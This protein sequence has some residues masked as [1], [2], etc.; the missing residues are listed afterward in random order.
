MSERFKTAIAIAIS[1]VALGIIIV[2]VSFTSAQEPTADD[3]VAALSAS[4]K[5]PFCSGESL[6][7]SQSGVARDYREL[8]AERVEA[9]ATDEE[10]IAEFV[11]NFGQSYI[12][13][14][15]K[16]PWTAALWAVPI[17]ALGVGG[18]VLVAL[19]RKTSAAAR[20]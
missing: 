17:V 11:A 2:G 13:D 12:L 15:S 14:N 19:K 10:I 6:A 5:C 9:G 20:T 8:I 7:D 18:A 1:V 4:I 3:R 16:S